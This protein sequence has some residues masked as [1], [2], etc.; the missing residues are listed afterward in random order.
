MDAQKGQNNGRIGSR[1]AGEQIFS[2]EEHRSDANHAEGGGAVE[3]GLLDF[4]PQKDGDSIRQ[5]QERVPEVLS[6]GAKFIGAGKTPVME[7]G[8]SDVTAKTERQDQ[9]K[10]NPPV[11]SRGWIPPL[12][13]SIWNFHSPI[14][15]SPEGTDENP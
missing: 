9:E 12:F 3:G 4:A 10:K 14:P 15:D 13:F 1:T 2:H 8:K 6:N 7:I 11:F 5:V